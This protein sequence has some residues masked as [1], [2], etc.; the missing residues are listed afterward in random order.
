M[1]EK[2]CLPVRIITNHVAKRSRS[3]TRKYFPSVAMKLGFV[4]VYEKSVLERI[5]ELWEKIGLIDFNS[6]LMSLSKYIEG[7]RLWDRDGAKLYHPLYDR[8]LGVQAEHYRE[9]CKNK[10]LTNFSKK[11]S[12]NLFFDTFNFDKLKS[13]KLRPKSELFKVL[14]RIKFW[15]L[16]NASCLV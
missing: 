12:K 7:Y 10:K 13:L 14:Y 15:Q 1:L 4:N 8:L 9:V 11:N 3:I 6:E 2:I 5:D 16:S